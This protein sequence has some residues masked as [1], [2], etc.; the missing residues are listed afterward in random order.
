MMVTGKWCVCIAWLAGSVAVRAGRAMDWS[1]EA[2]QSFVRAGSQPLAP[3]TVGVDGDFYGTTVTG[4]ASDGGTVFR[5]TPAGQ[6]ATLAALDAATGTAPEA[7]LVADATG[8]LYGTATTGGSGGF[9]T[10]FRRD[11]SGTVSAVVSFTGAAGPAKG[12]VPRGLVAHA[13]GNFYGITAAG[14]ATGL[15]TVFRMS[16]AGEITTLVEFTG[17]TGTAKGAEPVGSLTVSGTNLYGVTKRGGA[18]DFGVVFRLT[19]A[20]VWTLLAEFSGTSGSRPGANPAGPLTLHTDGFLYGTTEFGGSSGFGTAFKISTAGTFLT[21]RAF[22][23]ATGSQPAG[24]MVQGV[25]GALY[26]TTSAG[27]TNAWGT[28]FRMTTAG[29]YSVIG[30]F[31]G[32]TG[33]APGAAPR[34][35][36]TLAPDGSLIGATSAGGPG[37][38]GMVFRTPTAGPLS[39]LAA[40]SPNAGW[41]PSGAPVGD[42]SGGYFWPLA[43][44]GSHGGGVLGRWAPGSG[45][46]VAAALG[47]A[48]G[49]V[50][51]GAVLR[52]G[53]DFFGVTATGGGNGR[54]TAY[55]FSP[56]SGT[57]TMLASFQSTAGGL[58]DGPLIVGSDGALYGVSREGGTSSRGT[59]FRLTTGGSRTRVV[60]FSGTAGTARGSRPRGP[61]ALAGVNFYG[62]T[63]QGGLNNVGTLFKVTPAG[64]YSVLADFSASGPRSPR[65]G[66]I[67]AP[68]GKL[69]GT[70]SLGGAH[71]L[72]SL[73]RVDPTAGTWTAAADFSAETG[74]NPVGALAAGPD[75]ALYGITA[76]GGA[77][78]FGTVFRWSETAGLTALVSFT[79]PGGAAP[80]AGEYDPGDGEILTGGLAVAPDGSLWG[81]AP[82]GGPGGGGV[83][84]HLTPPSPFAEWKRLELGDSQA[85]DLGDP[86]ADGLPTLLEYALLRR[87]GLPDAAE[88]ITADTA[89]S[90][91]GRHLRLTVPRDSTRSDITLTVEA[92]DSLYGPWESLASS[93]HGAPFSGTGYVSGDSPAPGLH[94]VEI[95]DTASMSVS[96][97]RFIRLR[98]EH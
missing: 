35:G 93:V 97:S 8:A 13:D 78:G 15:G 74:G 50:P 31:T 30:D 63:E 95:R 82:G 1:Y 47:E 36:L 54:G 79:G 77:Q 2:V 38:M 3:L 91:D 10:V 71:G 85:P 44:G 62:L 24:S 55:R 60:S 87:P 41:T 25:D 92:A 96:P 22:V 20:G 61:L 28:V 83:F 53:A 69:Y 84:F 94:L 6:I 32:A 26:G 21:L 33:T 45:P 34:G 72:G 7:A 76:T 67:P 27:G 80:G 56:A 37:E 42:G 98:V 90:P 51:T 39:A 66:L 43:F 75:G 52:V 19:T 14:G 88:T 46:A 16:A 9:G 11:A 57:A 12:A 89:E 68:D 81:T 17:T 23:D 49:D 65:G 64:I 4:G 58:S 70:T 29:G 40:L 18:G 48:L 73:I 86:D 5:V 59:V